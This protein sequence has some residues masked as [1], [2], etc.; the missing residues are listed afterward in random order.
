MSERQLPYAQEGISQYA[1]VTVARG[2]CAFS[3]LCQDGTL[4]I[5]HVRGKLRK[6]VWISVGDVVLVSLRAYQM[7]VCDI[8]YR[9]DS[10]EVSQL[11]RMNFIPKSW[12]TQDE[13]EGGFQIE[14]SDLQEKDI[15]TL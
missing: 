15:D 12:T 13:E 3:V 11:S 7:S 2:N 5:A 1:K 10:T 9:Y 6:R 8:A 14:E 4:R